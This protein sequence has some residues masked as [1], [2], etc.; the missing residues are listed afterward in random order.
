MDPNEVD[1]DHNAALSH[2]SNQGHTEIARLLVEAGA[3][4]TTTA[5]QL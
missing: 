5:R 3:D 4:K 1:A 2:A